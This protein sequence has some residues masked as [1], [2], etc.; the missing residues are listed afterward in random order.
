MPKG[1][2]DTLIIANPAAHSGKGESAALFATRFFSSFQSATRSCAIRLT[3]GEGDARDMAADASSYN[4]VVALGGDGIIHE[5]A[6]GLLSIPRDDRPTLGVIPMGSGNDFA[7]TIGMSRNDPGRSISEL[8]R[9][10]PRPLDVGRVNGTY[11]V[12]TLSFGLDAQIALDT[13]A[14]RA[15]DTMQSGS[16]LFV[17]SGLRLILT[18]MRGWPY[19]ATIDGRHV[20]GVDVAFAVQN[21]KTYGGGF[22]ICPSA[23]PDDGM[24]DLCFTVDKPSLPHSLALF[25]LIRI[26]RHTRSRKLTMAR[27]RH[28]EIEFPGTVQ[29]PCQVDGEPLVAP[30][31][32]IDVVPKALD[33]IVAPGFSW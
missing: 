27:V 33:V 5:V 18:G 16:I 28:V 2:G 19:V 29:P 17:T 22:R 9:G 15:N 1:L 8:L 26:G 3:E 23:V 30:R 21:G 31:Y 32:V 14:R 25:G 11:F 12:Q 7:R 24:L 4:T 10:V 13:T 20:E 6:N